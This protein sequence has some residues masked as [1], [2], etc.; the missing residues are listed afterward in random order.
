MLCFLYLTQIHVQIHSIQDNVIRLF[1]TPIHSQLADLLTKAL[2]GQQ[3]RV[4]L[5]K[6]SIVNIHNHDSHL[7]GECQS[8]SIDHK[9]GEGTKQKKEE[10]QR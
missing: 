1:F 9:A 6:M 10:I 5:A 8:H 4:L 2:S 3:L 7:E